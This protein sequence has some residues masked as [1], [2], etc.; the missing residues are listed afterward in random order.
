[1]HTRPYGTTPLPPLQKKK[2][3][4]KLVPSLVIGML[5][6]DAGTSRYLKNL[7]PNKHVFVAGPP[8]LPVDRVGRIGC[9][10]RGAPSWV[11]GC[12]RALDPHRVGASVTARGPLGAPPSP[13][14]G[15]S[16]HA[17]VIPYPFNASL[18]ASCRGACV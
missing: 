8:P 12:V 5:L 3:G 14:V 18:I 9:A 2:K 10:L 11:W 16:C 4:A 17:A 1:M 7:T 15:P 6:G 13:S